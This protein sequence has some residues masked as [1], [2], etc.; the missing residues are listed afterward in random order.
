MML[1]LVSQNLVKYIKILGYI[2]QDLEIRKSGS[3]RCIEIKLVL[4]IQKY[5]FSS[6]SNKIKSEE[7]NYK[8]SK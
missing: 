8:R 7:R 4:D 5:K 6:K 2:R 3:C 1:R